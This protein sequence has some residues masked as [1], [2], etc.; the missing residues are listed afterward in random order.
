[1]IALTVSGNLSR[2]LVDVPKQGPDANERIGIDTYV[3]MAFS[4]L[5]ALA[6]ML[7]TA[8]TLHAN[9]MTDIQT[10][11]QAAEALKSV[12]GEFAFAIFTLGIL[13]TGLLA[14]PVL[15]GSAA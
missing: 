2:P 10:S 14:V 12:V 6:I 3:G 7:T 1:M 15:A 5:I 4:N 13:G 9:G 11:S 8:A